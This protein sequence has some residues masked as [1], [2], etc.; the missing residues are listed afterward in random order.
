M[1][2]RERLFRLLLVAAFV[3]AIWFDA[4]PNDPVVRAA[5]A[6]TDPSLQ[7]S[8]ERAT[9]GGT[10]LRL[11]L[12][13]IRNVVDIEGGTYVP[14]QPH[15]LNLNLAGGN[16][17]HRGYVVLSPDNGKGTILEDGHLRKL[18]LVRSPRHGGTQ[19]RIKP[20]LKRGLVACD[21]RGCLDVMKT[22]R[23]FARATTP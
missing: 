9:A 17:V 4:P 11:P 23:E 6:P 12:G 15:K 18:L 7:A 21:A 8:W 16:A 20:T 13:G 2:W 5:P 22:L 19:F 3:V 1:S 10:A 14:G